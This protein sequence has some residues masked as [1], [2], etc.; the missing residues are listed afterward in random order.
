MGNNTYEKEKHIHCITWNM[1][2]A[3]IIAPPITLW[4]RLLANIVLS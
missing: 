4:E 3:K 1:K 2:I